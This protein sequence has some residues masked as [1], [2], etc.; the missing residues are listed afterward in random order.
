MVR[1]KIVPWLVDSI[2]GYGTALG[3]SISSANL[4]LLCSSSI[5]LHVLRISLAD[6]S[7]PRKHD[8]LSGRLKVNCD[9][10]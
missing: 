4:L 5:D 8:Y 7:L 6:V 9:P 10:K 1:R 2:S 3:F